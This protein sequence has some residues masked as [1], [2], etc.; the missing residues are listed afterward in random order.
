MILT[1]KRIFTLA[2]IATIILLRFN[3]L[4]PFSLS[5]NVI[6]RLFTADKVIFYFIAFV[7]LRY[8]FGR[9]FAIPYVH[10]FLIVFCGIIVSDMLNGMGLFGAKET[11]KALGGVLFGLCTIII[12]SNWNNFFLS[13]KLTLYITVFFVFLSFFDFISLDNVLPATAGGE[14]YLGVIESQ[15]TSTSISD[16]VSRNVFL[17]WDANNFAYLLI[18]PI[19]LL[20]ALLIIK[21]HTMVQKIIV[22][23]IIVMCLIALLQTMSRGALLAGFFGIV[24]LFIYSGKIKTKFKFVFITLAVS[25][26]T[27]SLFPQ[28][29]YY[30]NIYSE[31]FARAIGYFSKSTNIGMD[32]GGLEIPRAQSMILAYSEFR[33]KPF[34]GWGTTK[35]SGDLGFTG[36]HMGYLIILVKHGIFKLGISLLILVIAF[37]RFYRYRKIVFLEKSGNIA[38]IWVFILSSAVVTLIVGLFK[39][40][41][42]I[43]L[44]M[45][46]IIFNICMANTLK[47]SIRNGIRELI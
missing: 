9:I 6:L 36:N 34:F 41:S 21:K 46:F 27:I 11:Y 14:Y 43:G 32:P 8:G 2:L 16:S 28:V 37:S 17:W 26:I 31:R 23:G 38:S 12:L 19:L 20:G 22:V 4:I 33:E 42:L 24:T 30:K 1:G 40:F 7:I 29:T 44:S 45:G 25:I 10:L 5:N 18:K 3:L 39:S 35:V 47:T 13:I 15:A